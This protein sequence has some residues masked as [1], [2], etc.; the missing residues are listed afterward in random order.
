MNWN[1]TVPQVDSVPKF[2]PFPITVLHIYYVMN[3]FLTA[4]C[5]SKT[6]YFLL[7]NLQRFVASTITLLVV[8]FVSKLINNQSR[9][10]SLKI[11]DNSTFVSLS[12]QNRWNND[13]L[14]FPRFFLKTSLAPSV[15]SF[16]YHLKYTDVHNI[17]DRPYSINM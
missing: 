13:F 9:S 2:L 14:N 3:E 7:K 5:S 16:C 6:K 1:T 11:R 17:I 12:L 8:H 10:E 15:V 4:C